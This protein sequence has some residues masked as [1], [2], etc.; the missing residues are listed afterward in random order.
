MAGSEQK[1]ALKI[2]MGCGNFGAQGAEGARVTSVEDA[3]AFFDAV[4][5]HGHSELDTAT[6]YTQGTSERFLGETDYRKR[7]LAIGTKLYPLGTTGP[8]FPGMPKITHRPE[9]LRKHLDESLKA[10]KTDSL[11]IWYLHAPDRTTPYE[12]TMKAVNDLFNESKFKRFGL[13]NFMS[14][15]VAELVE[16]CKANGYVRPTVYQGLYNAMNRNVEPE[17]F[18]CL[19]KYGLSFYGFN[20]LGGGFFT[21]RYRAM[22][23]QP[24]ASSR[25]DPNTFLGK[26]TRRRYWNEAYF[27]AL[28]KIEQAAK[29]HD[30]TLAEVALRW[31][32]H[33][34]LL[35]REHGDA[36]IIGAS[37]V[38]QVEQNLT[39]L[40]KGP[41]PADVVQALDEAWLSVKGAA[42]SYFH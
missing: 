20:P 10:L 39:D 15:E 1:S 21:G 38:Q 14:W 17:L 41:L 30:L 6:M 28:D 4:Q 26:V 11:D 7:G 36:V 23:D 34:S 37:K 29:N 8:A 2:I 40:E 19:R 3:Q 42:G 27:G 25:F 16:I 35:K 5:A 24:E 33:H 13:S 22:N 9:D 18:P 32:S 12:E 31:L